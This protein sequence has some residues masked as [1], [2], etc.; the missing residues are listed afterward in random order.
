MLC[1]FRA[2]LKFLPYLFS[3]FSSLE[4][5]FVVH[6]QLLTIV[7]QNTLM[8]PVSFNV[9]SFFVLLK[10]LAKNVNWLFVA[11]CCNYEWLM[12]T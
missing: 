4:V 7:I 8:L 12:I 11:L 5:M 9:I 3:F 1:G 10:T 2:K 6:G